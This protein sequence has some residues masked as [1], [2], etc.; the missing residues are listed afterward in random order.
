M[1][2]FK[3]IAFW[4]PLNNDYKLTFD[5]QFR[6]GIWNLKLSYGQWSIRGEGKKYVD[7]EEVYLSKEEAEEFIWKNRKAL[8]KILK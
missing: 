5:D 2:Q 7:L 1:Q 6:S 8:N 4:D 3:D